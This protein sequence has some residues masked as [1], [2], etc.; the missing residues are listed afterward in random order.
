MFY[1]NQKVYD[2][3]FE[4]LDGDGTPTVKN[5]VGEIVRQIPIPD[6]Y[7]DSSA[8]ALDI[9][10]LVEDFVYE[11]PEDVDD[12]GVNYT[13]MYQ[14]AIDTH[15]GQFVAGFSQFGFG[16]VGHLTLMQL[17]YHKYKLECDHNVYDRQ[18]RSVDTE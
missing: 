18:E 15:I 2:Y 13:V 6:K 14:V 4:M 9:A 5:A 1:F 10:N 12:A 11:I 16:E 3:T 17:I 7:I 8:M